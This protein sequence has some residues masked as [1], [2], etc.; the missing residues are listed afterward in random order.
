MRMIW[1]ILFDLYLDENSWQA[2]EKSKLSC[3]SNK[4]LNY[5]ARIREMKKKNSKWM[6]EQNRPQQYHYFCYKFFFWKNCWSFEH[7]NNNHYHNNHRMMM[8][9]WTWQVKSSEP[10]PTKG[11]TPGLLFSGSLI[12]GGIGGNVLHKRFDNGIK[13]KNKPYIVALLLLFFSTEQQQT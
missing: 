11:I 2:K 4:T 7:H 9:W 12:G 1:T 10:Q 8:R 5:K 6:V 3:S 13:K